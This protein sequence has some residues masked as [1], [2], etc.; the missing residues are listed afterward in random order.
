VAFCFQCHKRIGQYLATLGVSVFDWRRQCGPGLTFYEQL[1]SALSASA[2][3]SFLIG[4]D[5]DP[6]ERFNLMFAIGFFV[7]AKAC[8]EC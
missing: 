3:S 1:S 4:R 5:D 7:R 6:A 2:T 8:N